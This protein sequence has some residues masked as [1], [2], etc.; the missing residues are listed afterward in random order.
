MRTLS[1]LSPKPQQPQ[2]IN[3]ELH[4]WYHW[5]KSVLVH[6]G[7]SGLGRVV[8]FS[9]QQCHQSR[10]LPGLI[11][12]PPSHNVLPAHQ[13]CTGLTWALQCCKALCGTFTAA[14]ASGTHLR[15]LVGL[16]HNSMKRKL[17]EEKIGLL[18]CT[19]VRHLIAGWSA[20]AK[21]YVWHQTENRGEHQCTKAKNMY[22]ICRT[23]KIDF[24]CGKFG[25]AS[26]LHL[27]A[28]NTIHGTRFKGWGF[29]TLSF[30]VQHVAASP[31]S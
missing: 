21:N 20:G 27:E 23:W 31:T 8:G 16:G 28:K 19:R 14:Q 1:T 2:C 30:I 7:R 9:T 5:Q 12:P 22:Y 17:Q 11:H 13:S 26:G 10:S 29:L 4:Q 6:T 24:A 3:L 18:S 15:P 25:I